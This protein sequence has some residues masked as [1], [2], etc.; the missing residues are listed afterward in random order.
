MQE[1]NRIFGAIDLALKAT[2]DIAAV[3]AAL[4]QQEQPSQPAARSHGAA[5]PGSSQ[6]NAA[7]DKLYGSS[8]E[9]TSHVHSAG[10][11]SHDE[12]RTTPSKES[13]PAAASAAN[14]PSAPAAG[15]YDVVPC[16]L[17]LPISACVEVKAASTNKPELRPACAAIDVIHYQDA[18]ICPGP[19]S[20]LSPLVHHAGCPMPCLLTRCANC[21]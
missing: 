12:E 10:L 4:D 17:W 5:S 8:P 3:R 13:N 2:E 21:R 6:G 11:R 7:G 1:A 15:M 14:G 20:P 19:R 18:L 16:Q 9:S